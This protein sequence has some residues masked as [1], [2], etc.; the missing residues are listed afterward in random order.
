MVKQVVQ[1]TNEGKSSLRV[2]IARQFN[3]ARLGFFCV[4][5][6]WKCTL[7]K[8]TWYVT[9]LSGMCHRIWCQIKSQNWPGFGPRLCSLMFKNAPC[10]IT[11]ENTV[12]FL[13]CRF[14][15]SAKKGARE[16][17]SIVRKWCHCLAVF[18]NVSQDSLHTSSLFVFFTRTEVQNKRRLSASGTLVH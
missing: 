2:P 4:L 13:N 18:N 12:L 11:A 8:E 3:E 17:A 15:S 14:F 1:E 10:C 16:C 7:G 6:F 9:F 5:L